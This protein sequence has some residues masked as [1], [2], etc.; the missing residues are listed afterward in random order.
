MDTEKCKALI[1]TI[2]EGSLS[3]AADRLGYTPSGIS[4]M[5]AAL[6]EE[7]GFRLL[8]R[9]RSGVVPTAECEKMM[10]VFRELIYWGEQYR[11]YASEICG[12]ERG[13][14]TVGTSYSSYYRWLSELVAKFCS[15]YPGIEVRTLQANSTNLYIAM[16]EHRA[17]LCI[18]S[19]REPDFRWIPIKEDPMVVWV[20]EDHRA[21]TAGFYRDT[22]LETEGYIETF[23]EEETDNARLLADRQIK[24]MV[25]FSTTDN[26]ATYCMVESGLGVALMNGMSMGSWHGRVRAVPI[27]PPE[28]VS[29]GFICQSDVNISPAARRFI[30]FALEYSSEMK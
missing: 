25:K 20:P 12:L 6:E 23:P 24:P 3:A 30:D 27:E 18:V 1:A 16:E 19:R 8:A 26:Y 15:R 7:T 5:M 10:P 4:R 22:D 17:D 2:E 29:I 14:V 28:L 21:A 9:S 11:Q 13:T